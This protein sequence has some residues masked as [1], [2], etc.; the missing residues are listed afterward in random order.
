MVT[1]TAANTLP[2]FIQT[3]LGGAPLRAQRWFA[4]ARAA[5]A[6]LAGGA[7]FLPWHVVHRTNF[8]FANLADSAPIHDTGEISVC[9][10]YSHYQGSL[11]APLL[12]VALVGIA[13][14]G[15]RR[16]RLWMALLFE[17]IGIGLCV[18]LVGALFEILPHMGDRIEVVWGQTFFDAC[19]LVLAF[20][21]VA[22][23]VV[24]S[25]LA[26]R[27]RRRPVA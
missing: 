6:A 25:A 23:P 24:Q 14:V 8:S 12:A 2:P 18:G 5:L 20:L 22:G 21:Y 16:P 7:Y 19:S 1:D 10:G 17:V 26:A 27:S 11:A 13:L 15:L 4:G 9:T 3:Q